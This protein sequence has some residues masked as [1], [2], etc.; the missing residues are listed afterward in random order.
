[1]SNTTFNF[2]LEFLLILSGPTNGQ[3]RTFTIF[4]WSNKIGSEREPIIYWKSPE[5]D[6]SLVWSLLIDPEKSFTWAVSIIW[7]FQKVIFWKDW[8]PCYPIHSC[9]NWISNCVWSHSWCHIKFWNCIMAPFNISE[10][11]CESVITREYF[12]CWCSLNYT[13]KILSFQR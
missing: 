3:L 8:F 6:H 7:S 13:F 4:Q 5:F 12:N 10:S 2:S 9:S 11:G 1:M